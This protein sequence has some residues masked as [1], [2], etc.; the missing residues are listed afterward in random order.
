MLYERAVSLKGNTTDQNNYTF[1]NQNKIDIY[2]FA[3]FTEKGYS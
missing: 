1:R 2:T 3:P